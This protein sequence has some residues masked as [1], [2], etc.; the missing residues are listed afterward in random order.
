MVGERLTKGGSTSKNVYSKNGARPVFGPSTADSFRPPDK[1]QARSNNKHNTP[2][3][4]E[5]QNES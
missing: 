1:A 5:G 4:H 3:T 2:A